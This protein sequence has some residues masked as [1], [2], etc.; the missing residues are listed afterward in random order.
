[1]NIS[2]TS[3]AWEEYLYFQNND[4]KIM[5]RINGLIKEMVRDPSKGTGKPELL[6][7]AFTG[8]WSRRITQEHRIVYKVQGDQ[9]TIVQCR[10][11]YK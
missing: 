1:M 10:F 2:F 11:H 8:M 6:K 7:H 9:I 4:K 3:E 5:K